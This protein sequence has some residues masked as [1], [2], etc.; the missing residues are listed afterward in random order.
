MID[1]FSDD[2]HV[3]AIRTSMS[4]ELHRWGATERNDYI[5]GEVYLSLDNVLIPAEGRPGWGY[6]VCPP[7]SSGATVRVFDDPADV[8]VATVMSVENDILRYA[9]GSRVRESRV[10]MRT[11]ATPD[12]PTDPPTR[13]MADKT[14]G[15][16]E[17]LLT[18][19][20]EFASDQ[21]KEREWCG[22]FEETCEQLGIESLRPSTAD[23]DLEVTYSLSDTDLDDIL[24]SQF[25]GT[26]D[27]RGSIQVTSRITLV[28]IP[29]RDAQDAELDQHLEDAGY[30]DW[31][32][33][34]VTSI[35]ENE[36]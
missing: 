8:R 30:S 20:V 27:V 28:G 3:L 14:V 34:E 10:W 25:G 16:E 31:S 29:L 17:T 21:A 4:K 32:E 7:V 15:E 12:S 24:Q 2:P 26:H 33:Y 11:N 19:V 9:W 23:V 13:A 22:V 35:E 36:R 6:M 5:N 1:L 18:Q